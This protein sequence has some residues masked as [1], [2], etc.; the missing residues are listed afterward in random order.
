MTTRGLHCQATGTQVHF[1]ARTRM[2][3]WGLWNPLVSCCVLSLWTGRLSG[4][5]GQVQTLSVQRANFL[6][7][8][9]LLPLAFPIRPVSVSPQE[10]SYSDVLRSS[11]LVSTA[12]NCVCSHGSP[13]QGV[14]PAGGEWG[15]DVG[16]LG[17]GG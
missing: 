15:T 11:S 17:P 4:F 5:L 13:V 10:F 16:A 3:G 9:R 12:F 14:G 2:W 8:V 6:P 7:L 1:W